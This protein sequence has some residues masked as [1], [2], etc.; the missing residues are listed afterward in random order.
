MNEYLVI[1]LFNYEGRKRAFTKH[2]IA[3]LGNGF[4]L[5]ARDADADPCFRAFQKEMSAARCLGQL[6]GGR[7]RVHYA[8][9]GLWLS[10]RS[11][12]YPHLTR[13]AT[14][15]ADWHWIQTHMNRERETYNPPE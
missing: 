5:E 15:F 6:Y 4:V 12:P 7:R 3:K 14:G 9:E 2:E 11:C 8:R 10:T 13:Y 1:S